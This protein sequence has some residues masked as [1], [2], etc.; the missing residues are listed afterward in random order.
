[1]YPFP[2]SGYEGQP[3]ELTL[4]RQDRPEVLAQTT[5]E[6][7]QPR[8]S[9]RHACRIAHKKKANCN[10][11]SRRRCETEKPRRTTTCKPAE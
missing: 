10:S 4:R 2:G 8:E 9:V 11:S 6:I 3:I 5:V 1:M 7:G